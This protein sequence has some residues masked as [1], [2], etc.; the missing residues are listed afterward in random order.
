LIVVI[1]LLLV[2]H[3]KSHYVYVAHGTDDKTFD[4]MILSVLC[5]SHR[6]VNYKFNNQ[7]AKLILTCKMYF[8]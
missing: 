5:M 6:R 2:Q 4:F 8:S 1:L 7:D 3:H